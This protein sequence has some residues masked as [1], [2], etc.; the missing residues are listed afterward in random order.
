MNGELFLD[1]PGFAA[2][3][4][5]FENALTGVRDR[6]LLIDEKGRMLSR[7][8]E[9]EAEKTWAAMLRADLSEASLVLSDV[10]SFAGKLIGAAGKLSD[11]KKKA[12][13]LV[14]GFAADLI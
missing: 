6:L 13:F 1:G 3:K 2:A 7:I 4:E 11:T 8:W 14:E 10:Q 9:G 5:R 12:A